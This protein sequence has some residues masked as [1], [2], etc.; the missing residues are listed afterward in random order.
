MRRVLNTIIFYFLEATFPPSPQSNSLQFTEAS[1][2][3]SEAEE[4]N[5]V[6]YWEHSGFSLSQPVPL[7]F[8]TRLL[9]GQRVSLLQTGGSYPNYPLVI[10]HHRQTNC[11]WGAI[12]N[13]CTQQCAS[14][15]SGLRTQ[16]PAA[17]GPRVSP[18]LHS[19][20]RGTDP[21]GGRQS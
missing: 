17:V 15:A 19:G 16:Q 18:R 6:R 8:F 3:L 7:I 21:A 13:Y 5:D 2:L 14:W 10:I 4:K 11:S 12:L 1:S 20:S 9:H